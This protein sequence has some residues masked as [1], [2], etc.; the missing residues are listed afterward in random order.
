MKDKRSHSC[1]WH[2]RFWFKRLAANRD[3]SESFKHSYSGGHIHHPS[4]DTLWYFSTFSFQSTYLV[5]IPSYLSTKIKILK[6]RFL[7]ISCIYVAM[8]LQSV[9]TLLEQNRYIHVT[10][11]PFPQSM[12]YC[13]KWMSAASL[14]NRLSCSPMWKQHWERGAHFSCNYKRSF[15]T[16]PTKFCQWLNFVKF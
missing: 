12:L 14:T 8:W 13:K 4:C 5:T 3:L 10:I 7:I 11:P 9:T 15:W 6:R 2:F 16:V 1:L